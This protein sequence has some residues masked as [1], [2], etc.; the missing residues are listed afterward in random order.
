MDALDHVVVHSRQ[1][2]GIT[3]CQ[4]EGLHEAALTLCVLNLV[5]VRGQREV[6]AQVYRVE[7][8]ELII[9]AVNPLAGAL[10]QIR[11]ANLG[12]VV[13][14]LGFAGLTSLWVT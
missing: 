13:R 7:L 12:T 6:A 14:T 9:A 10:Q 4:L 8:L 2:A 3:Q 5:D 1:W 11:W